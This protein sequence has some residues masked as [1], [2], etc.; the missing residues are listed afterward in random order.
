MVAATG[1]PL[2]S[3]ARARLAVTA[4]CSTKAPPLLITNLL[5]FNAVEL[6]VPPLATGRTP[7]TSAVRLTADALKTPADALTT[8]EKAVRVNPAKVGEEADAIS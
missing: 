4:E 2:V 5:L 1:K 6:F 8:P 7:E 3:E